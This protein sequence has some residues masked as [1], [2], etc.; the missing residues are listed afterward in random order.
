MA[1]LIRI[2]ITGAK[3]LERDLFR[4]GIRVSDLDFSA[5]AS[6]GMRLA[7]SFAPRKSGALVR[8]LKASKGKSRASIRA[9]GAKVPYAGAINYGWARRNI[10]PARFMQR[11]DRVLRRTA[12]ARLEAQL[13]HLIQ[14]QGRL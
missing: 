4:L 14:Q 10:A 11:A 8:S 2:R 9:G 3:A 1:D 6:E 13:R 7:A 12:P 5:I